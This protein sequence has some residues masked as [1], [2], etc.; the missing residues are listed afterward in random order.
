MGILLGN[1]NGSFSTASTISSGGGSPRS[2]VAGDFNND[3]APDLAACNYG[4][5]NLGLLLSLN[6]PSWTTKY[7]AHGLPFDAAVGTF[8]AGELIQG[9]DN[10]FDGYGRLTVGGTPFQSS[11]PGYSFQDNGQ[12]AVV[13]GGMAAGLTISR[14]ITV[15]NTGSVDFAAH[16]GFV[17]EFDRVY[18]YYD[19][20]DHGQSRLRCKHSGVCKF[21]WQRHRKS[22]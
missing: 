7:S 12:T 19:G 4:S 22:Q 18:Y 10:A 16:R 15:P 3:G 17:Y 5:N 1:G 9:S 21:R 11:T 2:I 13:A 6:A 8:G 20:A 14:K